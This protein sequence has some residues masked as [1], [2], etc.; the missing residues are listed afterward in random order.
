M[1]IAI[2]A[3]RI[4]LLSLFVGCLLSTQTFAQ[5]S[6]IAPGRLINPEDLVKLLQSSKEKPLMLQVGSHTLF[7]QA[8]IPGSE[9]VGPAA[10]EAGLQ[11]LRKR[12]ES[13]PRTKFIVLYCGCCPWSHCPNVKPADDAL[14]A[15]GFTNVKVLYISDNFGTNWVDKGYPTA[16]GE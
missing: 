8:H 1:R 5:W 2:L 14:H 9:Y 3:R 12:V 10:N 11:Q 15:M 7:A 13:L 16:R 6:P 4:A